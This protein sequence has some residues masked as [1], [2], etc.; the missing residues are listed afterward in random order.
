MRHQPHEATKQQPPPQPASANTKSTYDDILET[1]KLLEE[2][3]PPLKESGGAA[4]GTPMGY[5]SAENLQR[6][7]TPHVASTSAATSRNTGAECH[8]GTAAQSGSLSETKMH[9]ILSYLDEMERADED[10]LSQLAR[11]RSEAQT[12]GLLTP[13][14]GATGGVPLWQ[15][16]EEQKYVCENY[17]KYLMLQY[18]SLPGWAGQAHVHSAT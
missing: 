6:L 11:S 13:G 15:Q 4:K 16:E 7:T 12:R 5:L 2:A 14:G 8:Q 18:R 9:S 1:L 17:D 10:M 3:P